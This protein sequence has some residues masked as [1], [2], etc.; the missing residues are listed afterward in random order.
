MTGVPQFF[1]Q[2]R[3]PSAMLIKLGPNYAEDVGGNFEVAKFDSTY[4][5]STQF[6][7]EIAKLK[8]DVLARSRLQRSTFRAAHIVGCQDYNGKINIIISFKFFD[9][10]PALICLLTKNYWR[11][12][13][14]P[15]ETRNGFSWL[16]FVAVNHK[17]LTRQGFFGDSRLHV[18][19][20]G[21]FDVQLGNFIF[22]STNGLLQKGDR[23]LFPLGE[24]SPSVSPFLGLGMCFIIKV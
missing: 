20:T 13:D 16:A 14:F 1:C 15:Q 11:E 22:E 21:S 8:K 2:S 9:D 7:D 18:S 17:D 6:A 24:K 12:V 3:L 10:R 23:L 4:I 19:C 5:L